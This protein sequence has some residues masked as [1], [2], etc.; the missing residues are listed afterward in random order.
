MLAI[1]RHTI[2]T[3]GSTESDVT[4]TCIPIMCTKKKMQTPPLPTPRRVAQTTPKNKVYGHENAEKFE[5]DFGLVAQS[6]AQKNK[7]FGP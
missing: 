4:L 6:V 7:G 3:I 1:R 5:P 2:R